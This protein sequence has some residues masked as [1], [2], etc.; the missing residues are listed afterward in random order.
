MIYRVAV[1]M[2]T[3]MMGM[4]VPLMHVIDKLL[5]RV[6]GLH[7]EDERVKCVADEEDRLHMRLLEGVERE[8]ECVCG[9]LSRG[10]EEDD[11]DMSTGALH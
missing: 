8:K 3:M 11:V 10:R 4:N 7:P 1:K 6:R 5:G 9:A 2:I